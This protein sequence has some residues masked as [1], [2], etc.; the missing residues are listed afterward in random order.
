VD[1]EVRLMR[2]GRLRRAAAWQGLGEDRPERIRPTVATLMALYT[3]LAEAGGEVYLPATLTWPLLGERPPP[4]SAAAYVTV[5][6]GTGGITRRRRVLPGA[7]EEDLA[8][9]LWPLLEAGVPT[10][11][12][13]LTWWR[14]HHGVIHTATVLAGGA[15]RVN[16]GEV[17]LAPAAAAS[18]LARQ[19]WNGWKSWRRADGTYLHEPRIRLSGRYPQ[20]RPARRLPRAARP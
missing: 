6:G 4:G 5:S 7:G 17:Y 13:Q 1:A 11:G 3:A 20:L 9:E 10:A 15:I 8:G 16:G 14:R 19:I 18:G 12:K 2:C